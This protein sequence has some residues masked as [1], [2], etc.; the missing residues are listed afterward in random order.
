MSIRASNLLTCDSVETVSSCGSYF[1]ERKDKMSAQSKNTS[2]CAAWFHESVTMKCMICCRMVIFTPSSK[3]GILPN[4]NHCF[5]FRCIYRWM[6]TEERKKWCP[7]CKIKSRFVLPSD[8]WET[9]EDAKRKLYERFTAETAIIPCK[10]YKNGHCK[11]GSF[12]FYKH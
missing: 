11:Y 2:R 6:F 4:C 10:Y 5:C 12:C 3:F 7:I 8:T 9:S 1:E